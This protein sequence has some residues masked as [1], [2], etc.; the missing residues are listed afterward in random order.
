MTEGWV[1]THCVVCCLGNEWVMVAHTCVYVSGKLLPNTFCQ[2]T[3]NQL[4]SLRLEHPLKVN[5]LKMMTNWLKFN[6]AQYA[7]NIT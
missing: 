4:Y 7:L 2:M 5:H 3:C 6:S 1:V